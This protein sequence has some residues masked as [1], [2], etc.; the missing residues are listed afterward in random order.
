MADDL[1][2]NAM[3]APTPTSLYKTWL[4]KLI[5]LTREAYFYIGYVMHSAFAQPTSANGKYALFF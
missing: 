2:I 4:K 5:F 1:G 3:S